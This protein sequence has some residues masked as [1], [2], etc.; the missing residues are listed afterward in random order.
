MAR[1][2]LQPLVGMRLILRSIG[3]LLHAGVTLSVVFF[4]LTAIAL[5]IVLAKSVRMT[6]RPRQ[7][8]RGL[9]GRISS[10]RISPDR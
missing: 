7:V 2:R 1:R 6:R 8:A 5:I 3:K 4:A 10:G 9:A